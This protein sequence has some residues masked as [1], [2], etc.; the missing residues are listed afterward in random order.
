MHV[1]RRPYDY[2]VRSAQVRW[3]TTPVWDIDLVTAGF[4]FTT[5]PWTLGVSPTISM[6][7]ATITFTAPAWTVA[8]GR[9]VDM[10]ATALTLTAPAW[11]VSY[12]QVT[13]TVPDVVGLDQSAAVASV[14]SAGLT[15]LIVYSVTGSVDPQKV[16]AQSPAAATVVA[17]SSPVTITAEAGV[18]AWPAAVVPMEASWKW[19]TRSRP[20]ISPLTGKTR[21]VSDGGSHWSCTLTVRNLRDAD[22]AAMQAFLSRLRGRLNRAQLPASVFTQQG[23]LTALTVNGA[24]QTGTSLVCD[25]ATPT[26][27]TAKSGDMVSV[28]GRLYMVVADATAVAGTV[29]LEVVP[30]LEGPPANDVAVDLT[31]SGYFRLAGNTVGWSN[32]PGGFASFESIEFIEDRS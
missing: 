16:T 17:L 30:P 11:S 31:P 22:K 20:M 19:H 27:G 25:G 6:D 7:L 8:V 18:Y 3:Q 21:T 4:E 26:T 29:T 12:A 1:Y 5:Y 10:D 24:N 14:R 2:A 28:E 9:F 23:T 15:P 13:S 32:A